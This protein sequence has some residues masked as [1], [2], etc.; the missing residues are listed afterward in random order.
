M[1]H[2]ELLDSG[3]GIFRFTMIIDRYELDGPAQQSAPV[4]DHILGQFDAPFCRSRIGHPLAAQ[5]Q[6][7]PDEDTRI[8]RR[9]AASTQE[10]S[11]KKHTK[12][13]YLHVSLH[14]ILLPGGSEKGLVVLR[15]A[16]F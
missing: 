13:Q 12:S 6:V 2:R 16:L 5:S 1:A 3:Y 14:K 15:Q 7:R 10:K 9:Q 8:R 11:H 4:I